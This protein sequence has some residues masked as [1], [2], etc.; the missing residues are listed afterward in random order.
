MPEPP[1]TPPAPPANGP[2][3]ANDDMFV[4]RPA[5]PF[6]LPVLGND[7]DPDGDAIR[8]TAIDGQPVAPGTQVTIRENGLAIGIAMLRADGQI[9]FR[10]H[11][12]IT[13]DRS[14]EYTVA[15]GR[16]GTDTATVSLCVMNGGAD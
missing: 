10:G 15:D 9:V 5:L 14:F 13:G 16:G 12:G 1:V 7:R 6:V 2:P 8:I 11:P 3:D 4:V